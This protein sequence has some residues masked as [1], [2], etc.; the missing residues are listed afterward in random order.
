VWRV[1]AC[2]LLSRHAICVQGSSSEGAGRGWATRMV[3]L[4]RIYPLE[5]LLVLQPSAT[6]HW[7]AIDE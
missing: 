4:A 5:K 7:K 6:H 2:E 3:S 1:V